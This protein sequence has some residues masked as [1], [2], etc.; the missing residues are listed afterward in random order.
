MR[1]L[2]GAS[3]RL[4]TYGAS[5][6]HPATPL[7]PFPETF[8]NAKNWKNLYFHPRKQKPENRF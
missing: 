6:I 3:P 7:K 2:D 5:R 1:G 8:T 4:Y